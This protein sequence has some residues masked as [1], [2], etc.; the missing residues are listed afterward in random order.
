MESL[1]RKS[2][3]LLWIINSC[4]FI[5]IKEEKQKAKK[6]IVLYIFVQSSEYL[7]LE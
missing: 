3:L 2:F 1:D 6:I 4:A 7:L 5:E